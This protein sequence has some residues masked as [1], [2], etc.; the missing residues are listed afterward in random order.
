MDRLSGKTWQLFTLIGVSVGCVITTLTAELSPYSYGIENK[1]EAFLV[2]R[3]AE[4]WKD[5]DFKVV[6]A[7]IT[8]FLSLYPK[9]K[10][11]DHLRG[12]LGDLFLQEGQYEEA[13]STYRMIT[14]Q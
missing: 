11:N 6:K 8:D 12:I 3:I 2:R 7:Q 10:I 14:N 4:Y 5:Q 13:L 9:S 1:E